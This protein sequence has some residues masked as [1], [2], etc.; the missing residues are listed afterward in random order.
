MKKLILKLMAVAPLAFLG[1]AGTALATTQTGQIA[2]YVSDPSGLPVPEVQ[3]ELSGENMIGGARKSVTNEDGE[4]RF[5]NLPPGSYTLIA[6]HDLYRRVKTDKIIVRLGSTTSIDIVLEP[7]V[8]Q[9]AEAYI[10]RGAVPVVDTERTNLGGAISDTFTET[11]PTGRSYQS[12]ANL[13]PGVIDGDGN[14]YVHGAPNN[15]NQYLLDGINITDPVTNTFST[16]FNFDAIKDVEVITG[17][18]DAEYGNATGAVINI[19]TKSGGNDVHADASL[20]YYSSFLQWRDQGEEDLNNQG[21]NLNLNVGGPIIRDKL[22]YYLSGEGNYYLSQISPTQAAKNIFPDQ[23]GKLHPAQDWRSFF[24]LAKLTWQPLSWQGFKLLMQGDPTTIFN[25]DQSVYIHPDAETQRYQGGIKV[26]FTSDTSITPELFL[27]NKLGYGHD[28]LFLYPMSNN[29]DLASHSN[30][31]TGATTV[32]SSTWVDDNRYRIQLQS[33][34][35]YSL[36]NVVGEHEFKLGVDAALTFYKAFQSYPGGGYYEDNG[37]T[38]DPNSISGVGLPYRYTDLIEPENTF[39]F[40][41]TEGVY[42]QDVWKPIRSLTIRPGVRFDSARMRDANGEVVIN[43]NTLSPRVGLS[44]D[45]F[46][47]NRTAL[48]VGYYQY[49]DTAT[50]GFSVFSNNKSMLSRTYEYNP[51]TEQ[52]DVF[53]RE[54]GGETG[55]AH[56]DYLEDP[57]D[58]R[59]PRTHEVNVGLTRE[60][61]TNLA[62]SVDG[63]FRY[64]HN[65]WEDDET[66]LQWN[67]DGSDVIGFNNGEPRYIYSLGAPDNSFIRYYGVEVALNKRFSDNWEMMAS[68]TWSWTEGTNPTGCYGGSCWSATAAFDNPRQAPYEFGFLGQDVRHFLK[69]YA[70]YR[71]PYGFIAGADVSY[72]SGFPYSRWYMNDYYGGYYDLRAPR[73]YQLEDDGTYTELRMPD[74]FN[75]NL[76]VIWQLKELTGQNLDL[77]ADVFNVFNARTPIAYETRNLPDGGATEFGDVLAKRSPL[78]AQFAIRYRY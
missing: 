70:S 62:L 24:G 37:L 30:Y 17:G 51:V 46:D 67:A 1:W 31:E 23:E 78:T 65:L 5:K 29:F 22:W 72:Q 11:V 50:L 66:N 35:S 59:R 48:R 21:Y 3:L 8:A 12:V 61:V 18:R 39:F 36:S 55:Y 52:Y 33:S 56:K 28:R 14:S 4:F 69:I 45:P 25:E 10:V 74:Y 42:L 63:I 26:G 34:L 40:G 44:W 54:N 13:M 77:I 43:L 60:L 75:T 7:P 58:Q 71:L 73:G 57:L 6:S 64:T 2:G 68:Y 15:Y 38:S 76:R 49:V 53:I 47:D 9:E 19:V 16:N 32:N 27:S 41:D 20:Y